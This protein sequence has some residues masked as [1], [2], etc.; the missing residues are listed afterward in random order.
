M[1][2][3][4]YL[5]AVSA[6]FLAFLCVSF[7]GMTFLMDVWTVQAPERLE[8]ARQAT[9]NPAGDSNVDSPAAGEDRP[10]EPPS[11]PLPATAQRPTNRGDTRG[12]LPPDQDIEGAATEAARPTPQTTLGSARREMSAVYLRFYLILFAIL[13]VSLYAM[14]WPPIL[15]SFYTNVMSFGYL[16]FWVPQIYRNA[17]RNSRR[18]LRLEFVVGQSLLR[19]APFVYL[20]TVSDNALSVEVDRNVAYVLIAWLWIQVWILISQEILG[21][22]FFVRS[23]WVPPAYDYHPLLREDDEESGASMPIGFTQATA[24]PSSPTFKPEE[25]KER[26]KRVFDCAI[27]MQNLE[28]PVVPA[29]NG[30]GEGSTAAPA[31]IFSRRNYMVTPC[32]YDSLQIL[33]DTHLIAIHTR[34]IFHSACLEG[35]LRYRLQC[36]ICREN[37]PP[38]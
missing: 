19:L 3:A 29:G 8:T 15:R 21:P 25:S 35:W 1:A 32:R 4:V 22:R 11:L 16:S 24:G 30:P 13:I 2:D 20:Y 26:G 5:A 33:T 38:L 36:P 28:V 23:V 31:S 27:C 7:F 34:H 9:T 10:E 12:I 37:L 18:A 17:M 14:M 6:A